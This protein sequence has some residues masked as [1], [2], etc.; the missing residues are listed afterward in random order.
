[1]AATPTPTSS[2]SSGPSDRHGRD[3]HGAGDRFERNARTFTLLTLLSRFTG[4][5]R[6]A[7]LSR[8]F[9]VGPVMDAFSFGFMVPNLFRRLFG[10]GAL[11]A[12]FLPIYARLDGSDPVEARRFASLTLLLLG[13]VLNAM[14]IVAEVALFVVHHNATDSGDMT[15]LGLELLMTMLPYMP[16]V[17]LVAVLGSVLQTHDRFGPTA[18]S[19][20]ILNLAIVGACVAFLPLF[21]SDDL[22]AQGTHAIIVGASVV[23]AG[24]LQVVW[25]FAAARHLHLSLRGAWGDLRDRS[26]PSWVRMREMLA[27]ALPMMLGLG[28]LQVNTFLDGLVASWPTIIGPTIFGV[29]FPLQDGAMST[30]ANA[31]RLY[32]FPLGVFGIAIA[33]AIFPVLSR[34]SKDPP[35]FL[36]T[37]RR[38]LRLTLFIG[39]PASVGL[40]L[41]GRPAVA[42]MLQGGRFTPEDTDRVAF[43]LLGYAPAIWSYCM[44]HVWTRAFYA[45]GDSKT[46]TRVAVG[47]VLLNLALNMT[48]IWT[49]LR[50]AG[51]AW[52]T[53][54]CSMIQCVILARI[55]SRRMGRVVDHEVLA[56]WGRTALVT[57][58]MVV[59]ML[60][61][62]WLLPS[63]SSWGAALLE[64][65]L[66]MGLGAVA[67]AGGAFLLRMPELRWALGRK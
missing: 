12:S 65:C 42:V 21:R 40:M 43:V 64:L 16:L 31:Q 18:A 33:S 30:L 7:T 48:L 11:S 25:S 55:L 8:A 59:P 37:L 27:Q 29:P 57:V 24:V 14:V 19:P 56:A 44:V 34:Q 36:G 1:M 50:E 15:R 17:C 20:L 10:E 67:A 4:L 61:A 23:L 9:G 41:V 51:L 49:D 58:G 22:E 66:L 28:V 46:P 5:A 39:L 6:D 60:V 2:D 54:I 52:S 47:M 32:E 45:S 62:H 35:A 63:S 38:G 13:L 3:A 53:A 26:A